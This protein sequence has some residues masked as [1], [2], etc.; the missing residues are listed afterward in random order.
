MLSRRGIPV[1]MDRTVLVLMRVIVAISPHVVGRAS[2]EAG[3]LK[4]RSS[5]RHQVVVGSIQRWVIVLLLLLG[6]SHIMVLL[7]RLSKV[8]RILSRER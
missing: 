2:P 1:M 5:G 7:L 3:V 6:P 8:R 4:P